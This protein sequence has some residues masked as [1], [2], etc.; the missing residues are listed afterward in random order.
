MQRQPEKNPSCRRTRAERELN[1]YAF[2]LVRPRI[3]SL[4]HKIDSESPT[5]L[6]REFRGVHQPGARITAD[7]AKEVDG[8]DS[9][10]GHAWLRASLIICNR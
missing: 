3:G 5:L 1:P 10:E 8:D 2:A 9:D 6:E 4:I 7:A